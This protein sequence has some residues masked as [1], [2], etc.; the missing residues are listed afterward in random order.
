MIM[1]EIQNYDVVAAANTVLANSSVRALRQL[2]V[3][4][5]QNEIQLS[6]RVR[7]FYHK[8]LAQEAVRPVTA[9]MQLVNRVDVGTCS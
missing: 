8:Q 1:V 4:R 9:G 3:D 5:S 2:R 7:S 6:G